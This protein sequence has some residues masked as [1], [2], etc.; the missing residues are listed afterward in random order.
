MGTTIY[1]IKQSTPT[2]SSI[3][4]LF[5]AQLVLLPHVREPL[6]LQA[7][8]FCLV[9]LTSSCPIDWWLMQNPSL[10]YMCKGGKVFSTV[11]VIES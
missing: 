11:K 7:D 6:Q 4:P 10:F 2:S 8:Q 3:P 5:P 1:K 9:I